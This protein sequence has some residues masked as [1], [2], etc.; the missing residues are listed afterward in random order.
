MN[1][2]MSEDAIRRHLATLV[3]VGVVEVHSL[4]EG[5]R[6]REFPYKFYAL[7]ADARGLFDRNNLFPENAWQRQYAAV[8]KTSRIREVQQMPRPDSLD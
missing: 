3:E 5:K 4:P 8:E 7:T 6:L 1:P 2:S